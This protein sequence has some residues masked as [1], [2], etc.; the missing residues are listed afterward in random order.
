MKKII[1]TGGC[2]FIGSALIKRLNA[3]NIIPII[4][5][6]RKP[7][8]SMRC[9]KFIYKNIDIVEKK[10]ALSRLFKTSNLTVVHL[11]AEHYIP[12]CEKYPQHCFR[13]NVYGT[14]N[15]VN[16]IRK[17]KGSKLIFTSSGAVYS[18]SAKNLGEHHETQPDDTYGKT[19]ILGEDLIRSSLPG[20]YKIFRLFNV[21]G[22]GDKT[23]HLIPSI[24]RQLK[25]GHAV[26][27]G[28]LK[29]ERDYIFIDDVVTVIMKELNKEKRCPIYN[30]GTGVGSSAEQIIATFEKLLGYKIHVTCTQ[31]LQRAVDK[32]SLV[33]NPALVQRDY[34]ISHFITLEQG[35]SS[36]IKHAKI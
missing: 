17:S 16:L 21:Y 3:E 36:L 29:T 27:L 6:I 2:G 31:K 24:I 33:S 28:T 4:I 26:K 13:T 22:H 7:S 10:T 14:H 12:R 9:L 8:R 18:S 1:I 35:L 5:D 15:I 23:P 20:R 34:K 19:K 11:A 30:V 25:K 32:P